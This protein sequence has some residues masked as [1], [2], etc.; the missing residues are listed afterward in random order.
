MLEQNPGLL[1][2]LQTFLDSNC[3]YEKER[4]QSSN[5]A[6]AV[7]TVKS[8]VK[9]VSHAVTAVTAVPGQLL[10]RVDTVVDGLSKALLV[11]Y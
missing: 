6:K 5:V 8:T 2:I 1:E 4:Q 3:G 11:I 10:N 9:G 7:G